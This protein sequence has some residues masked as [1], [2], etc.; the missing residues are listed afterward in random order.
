MQA[1]EIKTN[2]HKGYIKLHVPVQEK[3]VRV[4]V[5]WDNEKDNNRNYDINQLKNLFNQATKADIFKTI[6]NPMEWQRQIR[7][8]WQ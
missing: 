5:I 1:I 2:S 8:E 7:N 3:E 4:I 6:S